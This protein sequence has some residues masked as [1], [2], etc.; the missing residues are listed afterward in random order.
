MTSGRTNGAG[1]GRSPRTRAVVLC[2]PGAPGTPAPRTL[3]DALA[4]RGVDALVVH[5]AFAAAL[6][7]ARCAD[8]APPAL[9]VVEPDAHRSGL[10]EDLV[11]AVRRRFPG[12]ALWRFEESARPPLRALGSAMFSEQGAERGKES[13]GSASV[14]VRSGARRA[15]GLP[16]PPVLRL[17]GEPKAKRS[18][19][20]G[21]PSEAPQEAPSALLSE[22]ELAM[23]LSDDLDHPLDR[24]AR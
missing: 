9:I 15:Q 5:D 11:R 8:D 22:E 14:V 24:P 7:V 20:Q 3:L 1:K 4:R 19:E 12:V 13:N 16:A 21:A 10:I 2:A 23:L 6:V 17:T 18:S